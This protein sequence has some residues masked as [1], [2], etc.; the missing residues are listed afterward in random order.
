M[1]WVIE[2][3]KRAGLAVLGTALMLGWWTLTGNEVSEVAAAVPM[4]TRIG[5][6]GHSVDVELSA[7]HPAY[8]SVTFECGAVD[9]DGDPVIARGREELAVGEHRFH[10]DVEGGCGYAVLESGMPEPQLGARL[11]WN[12]RVDGEPWQEED[13]TLDKPLEPGWAFGLQT[14]WEDGTLDE[15]LAYH[16]EER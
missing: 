11:A 8:F 10:F 4:P 6:G 3:V 5:A 14:G 9:A 12:V 15:I 16:R 2:K 13:L 7:S 1:D